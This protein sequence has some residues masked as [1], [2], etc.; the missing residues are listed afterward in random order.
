MSADASHADETRAFHAPDGITILPFAMP[1]LTH[2]SFVEGRI[3]PRPEP[4][5]IHLHGALEQVTYVLAGRITVTTWDA[6]EEKPT[7]F[8]AIAGDAFVTLPLQTLAF[9]NTGPEE[10]R[11]LFICAPAYPPDDGDTRLVAAHHAPTTDEV[12]WSLGRRGAALDAFAAVV[13]A[14]VGSPDTPVGE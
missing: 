14:R 2:L 12:A 3:P 4:Y 11:V 8:A 9:A 5:P 10:A 13:R 6:E 7:A 1:G